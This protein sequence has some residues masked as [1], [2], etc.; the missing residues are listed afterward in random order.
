MGYVPLC[1]YCYSTVL[2]QLLQS[3][4]GLHIKCPIFLAWYQSNFSYLTSFRSSP[5]YQIPHKTVQ[6]EQWWYMWTDRLTAWYHINWKSTF[7][8]DISPRTIQHTAVFMRSVLFQSCNVML[9][10]LLHPLV[11]HATVPIVPGYLKSSIPR[12]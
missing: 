6:W 2:D 9:I 11:P 1:W 4:T 5:Q 10:P 8:G 12:C 7:C 3:S